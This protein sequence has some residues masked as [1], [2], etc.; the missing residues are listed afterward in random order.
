MFGECIKDKLRVESQD[1]EPA[2]L[3]DNDLNALGYAA[4]YVL[5]STLFLEVYRSNTTSYHCNLL[6]NLKIGVSTIHLSTM[7]T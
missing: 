5:G 2:E 7:N 3:T 1:S 4:E 6:R